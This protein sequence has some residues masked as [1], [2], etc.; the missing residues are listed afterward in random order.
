MT[1]KEFRKYLKIPK[2]SKIL[3]EGHKDTEI[4]VRYQVNE[5]R[6][7]TLIIGTQTPQQVEASSNNIEPGANQE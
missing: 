2:N 6:E 3:L 5:R 4:T 7:W 1:V